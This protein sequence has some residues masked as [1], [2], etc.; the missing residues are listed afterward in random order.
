M[1][2]LNFRLHCHKDKIP[3]EF[4]ISLIESGLDNK[5]Y[6]HSDIVKFAKVAEAYAFMDEMER[7]YNGVINTFTI[8]RDEDAVDSPPAPVLD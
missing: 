3:N 2:H 1:W 5:M 8:K 4:M 7:K 6:I